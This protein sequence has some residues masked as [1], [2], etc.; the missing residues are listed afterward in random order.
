MTLQ[1]MGCRQVCRISVATLNGLPALSVMPAIPASSWGTQQLNSFW[2]LAVIRLYSY[3]SAMCPLQLL[4][5][6]QQNLEL[7]QALAARELEVKALKEIAA[8]QD[9]ESPAAKV[10]EL[11]KKVC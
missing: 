10:I 6:K 4:E 11:S 9:Q 7:Q 1:M 5:M 3:D 8:V 2:N